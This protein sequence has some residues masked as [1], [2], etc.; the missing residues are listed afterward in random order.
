[1]KNM[2]LQDFACACSDLMWGGELGW[3]RPNGLDLLF[4]TI[5]KKVKTPPEPVVQADADKWCGSATCPNN[6]GYIGND[7]LCNCKRTA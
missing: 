4:E 7:S 2:N 1:M 3:D 6:K 5:K